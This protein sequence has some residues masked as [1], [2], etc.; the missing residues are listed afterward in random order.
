M[1]KGLSAAKA[2]KIL[3]DGYIKGKRL[4]AKQREYFGAIASGATPLKAIDG[5]E[6]DKAQ[7]GK[8]LKWG[9]ELYDTARGIDKITDVKK[10]LPNVSKLNPNRF[11]PN[12]NNFYHRSQNYKDNILGDQLVPWLQGNPELA[13]ELTKKIPGKFNLFKAKSKYDELYWS[14]GTPLDGRYYTKQ[15]YPGPYVWEMPSSMKSINK[16]NGKV[17]GFN[18]N[19]GSYKVNTEPLKV[20]D[21]KLYAEHWWKGYKQID[22]LKKQN[23]GWLDKFAMGGSLPGASGMMYSRNSGSSAM[24]PPNLTKAQDGTVEYGTPEYR[25]LYNEGSIAGVDA[26]GNPTIALDEVVIDSGVDYEKDIYYD[27]LTEQEKDLYHNDYGPIGTAVRRKAQT[28]KGLAEDTYDVVNPIMYGML[29][30]AGGMAFAPMMGGLSQL[31]AA[32]L[33]TTAGRIASKYAIR[34]AQKF[35][36]Y[37]PFNGPVSIGNT[38]DIGFGGMS[39]Y[40]TPEAYRQYKANP[41][42]DTGLNLA[43]TSADIIP[44]SELFTG[45]KNIRKAYNYASD[46]V[47]NLFR[48]IPQNANIPT[49][50][51]LET[52]PLRDAVTQPN[53]WPTSS[54]LPE[55]ME[56]YVSKK[57]YPFNKEQEVFESFLSTDKQLK[58]ID[59][60]SLY[61]DQAGKPIT[62]GEADNLLYPPEYQKNGGDV[63]KAQYGRL[64][65][66]G[67]DIYDGIRGVDNVVDVANT[68]RKTSKVVDNVIEPILESGIT[69]RRLAGDQLYNTH[70]YSAQQLNQLLEESRAFLKNTPTEGYE[71]SAKFKDEVLRKIENLEPGIKKDLALQEIAKRSGRTVGDDTGTWMA[72][73]YIDAPSNDQLGHVTTSNNLWDM[74]FKSDGKMIPYSNS[75]T[76][77]FNRG[78]AGQ[79]ARVRMMAPEN[80]GGGINLIFDNNSLKKSGI[81]PD[82][83]GGELTI[84]QDVSLKHLYPEAKVRAKDMLL[85]EAE[86]RG[87]EVTDDLVKSIDD[88]LQ[89]NK[90]KEGG[91]TPKAQVGDKVAAIA[92][93]MEANEEDGGRPPLGVV[94]HIRALFDEEGLCRDNTCV[95]TVKD[96]YSKAGVKAMPKD[97]YNNREF[98]K[99]FKEYGFEEILDQ[100]NL[101]PGDVLQYYY[102]PDSED[103]KEDP[104]YLNF[105]YHMGV[106]VNPGEY[107]GD[108]DSKAPIQ[109]KNM[110]TGT[111]D[112]KEY[113]K[114]PFRAFRYIKQNKN[115]SDVEK[116]QWGR[117]L[118]LAKKYGNKVYEMYKGTDKVVDAA[119]TTGK[120]K[121]MDELSSKAKKDVYEQ[122]YEALTKTDKE[123]RNLG[124]P[125]IAQEEYGEGWKY[126]DQVDFNNPE[127]VAAHRKRWIASQ[128]KGNLINDN[129]RFPFSDETSDIFS[130][131]SRKDLSGSIRDGL[132]KRFGTIGNTYTTGYGHRGLDYETNY[133]NDYFKNYKVGLPDGSTVPYGKLDG[134]VEID[135]SSFNSS[136]EVMEELRRL[137]QIRMGDQFNNAFEKT[138]RIDFGDLLKNKN[139]NGGWLSK[140]ENGGVIED[141]RGQWAH[142]GE[143][144][145]INSNNITMKGVNYPVLGVSDTGDTKMMQPGVDNYKYDGNSVTEYPMAKD[146]KSLVELDQLTNFTNYNTPQPGGWLDKY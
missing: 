39:L 127:E 145:K 118:K 94:D 121:Y 42:F 80:Q 23:G 34:P 88:Y 95:Q 124:K 75:E 45:G 59:S 50:I 135:P 13:A 134:S 83:S 14:K 20:S 22:P 116:A 17:K 108:G 71:N 81:L 131:L 84:S 76:L 96:F 52:T 1:A 11:E 144:T 119:S 10:L 57:I 82:T 5:A 123:T 78:G 2:K 27:T 44:Y 51:N 100:K 140:Y 16:V 126:S 133:L 29:G 64:L 24:S 68:V 65:K 107:I 106:Y 67:K 101:Q 9:K 92:S 49:G 26:D 128:K 12:P 48:G 54:P 86:L 93:Q 103:V 142:P 136:D 3:Q 122:N 112:G 113:K 114:D 125:H 28:K 21:A 79:L 143:V 53:I 66:W 8:M 41:G 60:K 46:K 4:T 31:P 38:I 56:P 146:G 77:Y 110:Y 141:D 132:S 91:S 90:N 89:I 87:V 32:A 97:V 55:N 18:D 104:S 35:L 36:N 69:A 43:L 72:K 102:G 111:K 30:V 117:L 37:K 109:R 25:K 6:V 62:K 7:W 15:S 115:G 137:A 139:R 19:L 130:D 74:V 58:N 47:S 63:D 73:S 40:D 70:R 33:N 129:R 98:L 120:L 105:P 99:N 61:Y 85:N 138:S